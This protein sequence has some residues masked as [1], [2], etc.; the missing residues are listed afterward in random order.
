M[1]E[2]GMFYRGQEY[3]QQSYSQ[4]GPDSH[5]DKRRWSL[6]IGCSGATRIAGLKTWSGDRAYGNFFF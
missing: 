3:K 1:A 2:E 4:R 6:N 5:S